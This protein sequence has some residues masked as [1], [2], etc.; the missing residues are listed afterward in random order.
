MFPY[1][2]VRHGNL[3]TN[4]SIKQKMEAFEMRIQ[5]RRKVPGQ[6]DILIKNCNCKQNENCNYVRK[7][8]TLEVSYGH[9]IDRSLHYP[10]KGLHIRIEGF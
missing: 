1:Y 5:Y 2:Y 3:N 7:I 6:L 8:I 10:Q 9:F 4:P